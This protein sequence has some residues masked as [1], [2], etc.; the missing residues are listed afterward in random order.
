MDPLRTKI[1][2][3]TVITDTKHL[4]QT[5]IRQ[6][7]LVSSW[8]I[9][10]I[11]SEFTS[12]NKQKQQCSWLVTLTHCWLPC[13]NIVTVIN[14]VITKIYGKQ[15]KWKLTRSG[16]A[17]SLVN[18]TGGR[19]TWLGHLPQPTHHIRY[20]QDT[21]SAAMQVPLVSARHFYNYGMAPAY[22]KHRPRLW[23]SVSTASVDTDHQTDSQQGL[24]VTNQL[25]EQF[26]SKDKN[27]LSLLATLNCVM[28]CYHT[29]NYLTT[30]NL[31]VKTMPTT[32]V[33]SRKET[34]VLR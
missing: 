33:A 10:V 3:E 31:S 17:S 18:Q 21:T 14:W 34:A 11:Q 13:S 29:L 6:H 12:S 5:A 16:Q 24:S 25:S 19:T 1:T 2:S 9:T 28:K 23:R 4:V 26:Q 7:S 32:N 8:Q 27:Y 30:G 20:T 15:R 22:L